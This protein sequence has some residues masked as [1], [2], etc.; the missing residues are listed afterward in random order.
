MPS[1]RAHEDRYGDSPRFWEIDRCGAVL[2]MVEPGLDAAP[3]YALR[4]DT[5]ER[6]AELEAFFIAA[7]EAEG[8]VQ[9][10]SDAP[11]MPGTLQ[12]P[13]IW[14]SDALLHAARCADPADC[15]V[16]MQFAAW[17]EQ[18]GDDRAY[19]VAAT[20][21]PASGGV[22]VPLNERQ[23]AAWLGALTPESVSWQNGF[24]VKAQ[25]ESTEEIWLHEQLA[26]LL[27]L[28]VAGHL[29]S[30]SLEAAGWP[31]D[32]LPQV[33]PRAL[34]VLLRLGPPRTLR[35]LVLGGRDTVIDT[36]DIGPVLDA[37]P[38]LEELE[39]GGWD[40]HLRSM[41][42]PTL[43][44]LKLMVHPG[45]WQDA[46]AE[47]AKMDMPA[48]QMLQL[49]DVRTDPYGH[50]LE[51]PPDLASTLFGA[52]WFRQLEHLSV[53][54]LTVGVDLVDR[55]ATCM[56]VRTLR[57]L[58]MGRCWT[59][60]GAAERLVCRA[61]VFARIDT[62]SIGSVGLSEALKEALRAALPDCR[63]VVDAYI[64]DRASPPRTE[65]IELVDYYRETGGR[66][67]IGRV[68]DALK[69]HGI[70]N[71]HVTSAGAGDWVLRMRAR[72]FSRAALVEPSN[73]AIAIV[74]EV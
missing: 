49:G 12:S 63:L 66:R 68:H 14:P 26:A 28:P 38:W 59:T 35:R 40:V 23:R 47:I 36:V 72:D 21:T 15:A 44:A 43:R 74:D 18:L 51:M 32:S 62:L 64:D 16:A 42:S 8:Y 70:T 39:V 25:L 52:P 65:G 2:R 67:V 10:S 33:I 9:V 31:G 60:P 3:M 54:W 11:H 5:E 30:L 34:E 27:T 73:I 1:Y 50:F 58:D 45:G 48:L 19:L 4:I 46:F 69:K 29:R 7:R 56:N 55:L 61:D 53:D 17:L 22:E 71:L 57:T 24:V 20:V 13:P 6:A 37:M 41:S